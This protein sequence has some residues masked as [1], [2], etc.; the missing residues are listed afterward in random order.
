MTSARLLSALAL[1]AAA[2]PAVARADTPPPAVRHEDPIAPPRTEG[3]DQVSS[4]S[5]TPFL[6]LRF[7][8]I[9]LLTGIFHAGVELKL[10]PNLTLV[11]QVGVGRIKHRYFD[12]NLDEI[13]ADRRTYLALELQGRFYP[14]GVLGRGI[15]IA[16]DA[17]YTRVNTDQFIKSPLMDMSSGLHVGGSFGGSYTSSIGL[18]AD[19]QFLIH[20][21]VLR[22]SFNE[23]ASPPEFRPGPLGFGAA[24]ALT[25]VFGSY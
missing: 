10:L 2:S 24:I 18:G 9:D 15:Y 17:Y 7:L 5:D 4:Y 21:R 6:A 13:D 25:Y 11:P 16:A 22:P 19:M 23:P 14:V 3:D 20:G 12:D 8:P 1:V